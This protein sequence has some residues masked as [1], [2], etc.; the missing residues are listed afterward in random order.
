MSCLTAAEK[1]I[2]RL[3]YRTY[4][5]DAVPG[6]VI[7]ALSAP[8]WVD[9]VIKMGTAAIVVVGALLLILLP[10]I[11]IVVNIL[12][13]I[14]LDRFIIRSPLLGALADWMSE[15]SYTR[16]ALDMTIK[17]VMSIPAIQAL[18]SQEEPS[19][20][21]LDTV[22]STLLMQMNPSL[23]ERIDRFRA[24]YILCRTLAFLSGLVF[25]LI[26]FKPLYPSLFPW[27]STPLNMQEWALALSFGLLVSL[28]L[29]VASR[30]VYVFT[31]VRLF[32]TIVVLCKM[33]EAA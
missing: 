28:V 27:L 10:G 23:L 24:G 1:F 5:T 26:L 29:L 15:A 14:V 30:A 20:E 13:Y 33:R 12:G 21:D 31:K 3:D 25:L 2:P 8:Y 11:G 19:L 17:D 32:R 22:A 7:V 4:L 18:F 16:E 9:F 6:A